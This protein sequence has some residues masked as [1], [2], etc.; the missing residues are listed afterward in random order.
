[1]CALLVLDGRSSTIHPIEA[2]VCIVLVTHSNPTLRRA[3]ADANLHQYTH[4]TGAVDVYAVVGTIVRFGPVEPPVSAEARMCWC[5]LPGSPPSRECAFVLLQQFATVGPVELVQVVRD[6]LGALDNWLTTCTLAPDT[7]SKFVAT[8]VPLPTAGAGLVAFG[9]AASI[10]IDF[11]NVRTPTNRLGISGTTV[12]GKC[13]LLMFA[14]VRAS[15]PAFY[16]VSS[17]G[18]ALVAH[19]HFS[20]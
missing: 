10:G 7:I 9:Q 18:N 12:G 16:S 11:A 4:L 17:H 5:T 1:M 13:P 15:F 19:L 14:S 8:S 2:D 3:L 20:Q 6:A